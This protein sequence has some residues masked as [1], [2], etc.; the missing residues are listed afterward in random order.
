MRSDRIGAVIP[1]ASEEP[2]IDAGEILS[3]EM[4]QTSTVRST[5]DFAVLRLVRAPFCSGWQVAD[6]IC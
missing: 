4:V 5:F 3:H 6:S 1:N 2:R